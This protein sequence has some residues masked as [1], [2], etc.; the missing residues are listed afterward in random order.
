MATQSALLALVKL[1]IVE[2]IGAGPA[3]LYTAILLKSV[4][5]VTRVRFT[6]QNPAD[7]TFGFGVIFSDTALDLLQANDPET[8]ALITPLME[9]WSDM[10]LSLLGKRVTLDGIGFSA[11]GR[12]QLL[13]LL[14]QRAR[15][16]GVIIGFNDA[17][18]RL[19]DIEAEADLIVG[20]DG[21]NSLLRQTAEAEF[22]PRLDYFSNHFAWFGTPRSF[23][24]LIEQGQE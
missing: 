6:E 5:P 7:A 4:M 23:D 8:H 22:V 16:L 9:R 18:D 20:A 21:L 3:G 14:Q 24:T 19:D 11:I 1:D 13:Q 17:L 12:L 15:R 10:T 2:I